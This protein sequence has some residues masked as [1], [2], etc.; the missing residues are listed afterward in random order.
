MSAADF[1]ARLEAFLINNNRETANIDVVARL[2]HEINR[3]MTQVPG[4]ATLQLSA[5][6]FVLLTYLTCFSFSNLFARKIM[7]QRLLRS[8]LSQ[9][10]ECSIR[11]DMIRPNLPVVTPFLIRSFF[12]KTASLPL[13]LPQ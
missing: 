7:H 6:L 11:Y 13:L 4:F 12:T 2:E 10:A 5:T 1:V 3:E 8:R 9:H